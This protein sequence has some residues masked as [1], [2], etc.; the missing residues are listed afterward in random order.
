MKILVAPDSFKS[1]LFASQVAVAMEEGIRAVL[2]QVQVTRLPL[3][4]GGEGLV[5][6]LVSASGGE[7]VTEEVTDPLG[8]P[9]SSYWG[10]M[11]DKKTAVIEMAAASGLPLLDENERN[12]M[13][14]TTYG[15]GQLIK[16]ALDRGCRKLII[17]IGGSATND[18]GGGMA[19]ALGASLVDEEG[20]EL[21]FGGGYLHKLRKIDLSGMDSR[22]KNT[23]I[24][25]AC[26][27]N[28]PLTGS[29]GASSVYGPQKGATPDMVEKL[30]RALKHYA[31]VIYRDL[32][33]DVENVPGSGAAGG[34]GA[35]LMAFLN[36]ELTPGIE[37]VMEAVGLE[38]E[39][40][41][42]SLILT[43]EGELDAQSIYG[44]VPVGVARAA[45]KENVPVVVL[46]GSV[47]EDLEMIHREGITACFSIINQP[48][49]LE[50][51]MQKTADLVKTAAEEVIRL[52]LQAKGV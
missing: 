2:P 40:K 17:G 12:P 11:G 47:A 23:R 43:G 9:V 4:D 51:A 46:A 6:A 38:K 3:S 36:G 52:W 35:G 16:A 28:N 49:T 22:L 30:D 25:V 41:N 24:R 14:T 33:I 42:C 19:Q 26:D 39:L 10:L 45:K 50:D 29:R 34:L 48:M 1:S 13:V 18:G 7:F 15:T 37:L 44:K 5:D 32:G 8:R 20:R 21:P 31:Q 27:V